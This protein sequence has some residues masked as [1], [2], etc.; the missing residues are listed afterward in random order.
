MEVVTGAT[1]YIGNIL[2]RELL[3]KGKKVR[4]LVRPTSDTSSLKGL[5][6]E[7]VIG[8]ILDKDSLIRA[9]KGADTIYHL[10]AIISIMP[11]DRA[12]IRRVN[13]EGTRNVIDACLKCG[14]RRLVYTSSIHALKEPPHGTVIDED[15][16]FDV[17]SS[18]GEYDRSKACASQEVIESAKAGLDPVVVCPTGVVGPFDY[19]KSLITGTFIDFA[20]GKMKM[21]TNGAYD[22]VDARDVA[23]GLILAAENGKTG[24]YYILSGERVT[25]DKMMSMLSEISGVRSPKYKAPTWLVKTAGIFTPIY[26]KLANKTPRFTYYSVKTLLSN[27][28]I[29]HEKASNELGYKPM[30]I[31]KSIEDTLRWLKENKMI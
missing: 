8:D 5:E 6:I 18:R 22:F 25:M 16:S 11:G 9:F 19:R 24:Q 13:L 12:L 26:Y 29:S 31:R 2:T 23:R 27:S 3:D 30:T 17:N 4:V 1:G 20:Q 15:M 28:Y 14:V 10:A 21:T 7:K